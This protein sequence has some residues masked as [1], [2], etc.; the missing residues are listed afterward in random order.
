MRNLVHLL[1]KSKVLR[2]LWTWSSREGFE[3]R[4]SLVI[5][6]PLGLQQGTGGR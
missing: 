1:L 3:A 2:T 5:F 6:M 4:R